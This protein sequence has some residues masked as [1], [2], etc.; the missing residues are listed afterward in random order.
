MPSG[1]PKFED[2]ENIERFIYRADRFNSTVV[3]D[4][5]VNTEEIEDEENQASSIHLNIFM[6]VAMLAAYFM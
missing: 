6:F 1:F 5:A 4:P 3:F 2:N